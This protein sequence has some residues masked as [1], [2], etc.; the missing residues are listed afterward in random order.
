[1]LITQTPV[2]LPFNHKEGHSGAQR[3]KKKN[4]GL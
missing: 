2:Y 1:M 3:E 4:T